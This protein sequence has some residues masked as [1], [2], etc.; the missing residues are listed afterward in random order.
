MSTSK[1]DAKYKEMAVREWQ[2]VAEG[3][4]RRIHVISDWSSSVTV[5][6]LDLASVAPGS[7]VLDIA[8]GDGRW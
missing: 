1:F 8:A 4:H 3:W 5:Q 6:M 2:K 7:R